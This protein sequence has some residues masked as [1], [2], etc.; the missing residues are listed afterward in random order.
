MI[1]KSVAFPVRSFMIVSIRARSI[2]DSRYETIRLRS[3]S[4]RLC[5][6][7][8]GPW[9]LEPWR[10]IVQ[11]GYDVHYIILRADKEETFKRAIHRSKLDRETNIRLVEVMW[12]Q[13]NDLEGYGS[14]VI[15]TTDCLP[16]ETVSRIKKKIA[17][18]TALLGGRCMQDGR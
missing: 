4:R 5:V 8:I 11:E 9:F 10:R 1:I 12:E 7:G 18:K 3:C 13:F 6:G 15:D 17:D 16:Q 2:P 14:N